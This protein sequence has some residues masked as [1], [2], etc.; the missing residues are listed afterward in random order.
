MKTLLVLRHAKSDWD[1]NYGADHDRPLNRR[2]LAAARTMG[3]LVAS[4]HL[5]PDLVISSTAVRARTTAE[6]AMEGG[7]WVSPLVLERRLYESGVE[8]V[9]EVVGAGA[10]G[11]KV[12]IVGH[13]PT[14]GSLV[15]RLTGVPTE[16]KTATLVVI[17]LPI[18]EWSALGA[19]NGTLDGVHHPLR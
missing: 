17:G 14:W 6:L 9:L 15:H 11:D 2:G 3:E 1:A 12:M 10:E 18:G 5:V 13:Q 8:Q 4:L 7:G 16:I 19:A